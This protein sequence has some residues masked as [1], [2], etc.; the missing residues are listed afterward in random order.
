MNFNWPIIGHKAIID[1][2]QKSIAN[3]SVAHAYIFFGPSNIGKQLVAQNFAN[4]LL[5]EAYLSKKEGSVLPCLKCKSCE[6]VEKNIYAD[7]F[8]IEREVNEKTDKK[9][10][11]ITV[12]QIRDLQEKINKRAFL[13]SYKV[14]IIKEAHTLNQEAANCLLKTLEEPTSKTVLILIADSK[15]SLLPTII[16]RCQLFKFLPITTAEIYDYLLSKGATRD[17]AKELSKIASGRPQ[18]AKE[19]MQD[20]ILYNDYKVTSRKLLDVFDPSVVRKFQLVSEL[21]GKDKAVDEIIENLNKLIFIFRDILLIKSQNSNLVT[22]IA[23]QEELS[24]VA[25]KTKNSK[26]ISIL[27]E[28]E[29]TKQLIIQNINPKFALENLILNI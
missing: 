20:A 3:Q 21:T 29:K 22:N 7:L 8:Y 25:E 11:N 9:K 26:L 12:S 6:Q 19:F 5:C 27:K 24:N 10:Q 15:E 14:V 4:S 17:M 23:F 16:S 13:N 1:F 18:I 28:T 2:L